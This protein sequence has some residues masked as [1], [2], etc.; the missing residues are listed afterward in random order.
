MSLGDRRPSRT[1]TPL[2]KARTEQRI[3]GIRIS[4]HKIPHN[5]MS[6]GEIGSVKLLILIGS[7]G[8]TQAYILKRKLMLWVHNIKVREIGPKRLLPRTARKTT[9][10]RTADPRR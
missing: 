4:P 5:D 3:S 6:R 9:H 1:I 2:A 7:S 8:R 10:A